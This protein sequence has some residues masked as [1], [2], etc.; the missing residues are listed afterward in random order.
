MKAI[1]RVAVTVRPRQPF[2]D[3]VRNH[4]QPD[5]RVTLE[6]LRTDNPVYLIPN[7]ED[8]DSVEA[9]V[10]ANFDL[11][12]VEAL[13]GW[14]MDERYWPGDRTV[15]MFRD[16]FDVTVDSEVIDLGE[17]DIEAEEM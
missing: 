13:N 12:F 7:P 3:W 2:L 5:A 4:P 8:G 6:E 14:H 11:F 9:W 16:W 15:K 17:E 10:T 1:N